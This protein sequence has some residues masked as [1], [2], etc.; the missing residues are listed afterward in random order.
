MQ[1]NKATGDRIP[2]YDFN[3]SHDGCILLVATCYSTTGDTVPFRLGADVMRLGLPDGIPNIA[4]FEETV[5]DL[6]SYLSSDRSALVG[7]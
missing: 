3:I 6:V 1:V 7:Y 5:K 2:Y 4:E